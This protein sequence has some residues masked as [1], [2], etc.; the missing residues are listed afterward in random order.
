MD[1]KTTTEEEEL[2][3]LKAK[4]LKRFSHTSLHD[5]ALTSTTTAS[6]SSREGQNRVLKPEVESRQ[7]KIGDT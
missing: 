3:V 6:A 7:K 2:E 4:K 1:D 5:D